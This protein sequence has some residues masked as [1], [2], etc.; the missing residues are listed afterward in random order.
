MRHLGAQ[1]PGLVEDQVVEVHLRAGAAEQTFVG[2]GEEEEVLDEVLDADVLG[3]H[4]LRELGH[5]RAVRVGEGH[6]RMLTDRGDWGAQLVRRVG[7]EPLLPAL[8]LVEAVEHPV[9]RLS[10]AGDLVAG[11]RSRDAAVQLG[12]RDLVHLAADGLDRGESPSDDEPRGE[13]DHE[14]E[15]GHPRREESAEHGRRLDDVLEGAG[16]EHAA[17]RRVGHLGPEHQEVRLVARLQLDAPVIV[18]GHVRKGRGS[19]HTGAR[20]HHPAL[21]VE[22]LEELLVLLGYRC[23]EAARGLDGVDDLLGAGLARLPNALGQRTA[24]EADHRDGADDE[25]H[26]HDEHRR[27]GRAEAHRADG[28]PPHRTARCVSHRPPPAGTRAADRLDRRAVERPVHLVAQV[29]DVD[30]D[31]VGV[32]VEVVVPDV[33]Q[34]LALRNDLPASAQ[35]VLEQRALPRGQRDL[36]VAPPGHL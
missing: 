23:R 9:H 21:V 31:D 28:A 8:R 29:P 1:A 27:G 30:L 3:Q 19:G 15:Q 36:R 22:Q 2:T 17:S 7:H 20:R 11:P 6:L 35:Q 14:Q 5:R 24:Q 26:P 12:G 33:V 4:R 16:D 32:A 10:Q 25:R 13:A 34:H 18:D